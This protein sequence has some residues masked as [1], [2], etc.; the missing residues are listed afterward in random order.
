MTSRANDRSGLV[1]LHRFGLGARGGAAGDLRSAALDPRGY[2][3]AELAR[4]GVALLEVPTLETSA[5]NLRT[6]FRLQEEVRLARQAE[7]KEQAPK[8]QMNAPPQQPVDAR[9]LQQTFRAETLARWQRQFVVDAGFVERLVA[10]WSNHFCVSALKDGFVRSIAGAF[11]R[12]AI[13]PYVLGR[14]A[15]MLLAVEQHPAMLRFL[16]NTQSFGPNSQAGR[17]QKRGLNENLAREILELHT[18]GVNGGYVQ[19]DVTSLARII[20]G[21]TVV[22]PQAQ[23]GPPG[24]FAFFSNAHEPGDHVVLGKTYKANGVEQGR[25]ALTDIASHPSTAKFIAAKFV[26]H[27]VSDDPPKGLVKRLADVFI[28]TDGDLKALS[29]ALIK[30]DEAWRAPFTKMRTPHE[31]L[32]AATRLIGRP[33]EEPGRI[34]GGAALL[35]QPIWQPSGPN[36]FTDASVHWASAEGVKLRLEISSDIANRL[37]DAM[38]ALD[39]AEV[40][41][42]SAM[43]QDT[44]I[45]IG[46]AESKKQALALLLMSPEFQRR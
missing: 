9:F 45:T 43:S 41:F 42:G 40:A 14:F 2:L 4:P 22:G 35:G 23:L 1:A 8:E 31:F 29:L 5:D 12:E 34:N 7:P 32:I 13:R 27:F 26:A 39:L 3:A 44:R 6:L 24:T 30:D 19:E 33:L 20:T 21:W 11:E 28:K 10:F 15:D 46:R 25:R 18:L 38:N 37:G 17:N 16:D 36:G